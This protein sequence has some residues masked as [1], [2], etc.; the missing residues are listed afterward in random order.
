MAKTLLALAS[1]V[2]TACIA[3]SNT[4]PE[5]PS[6]DAALD[7]EI[8]ELS[9]DASDAGASLDGSDA[10][11]TGSIPEAA[12]NEASDLDASFD[13]EPIEASTCGAVTQRQPDEG[14]VHF[15]PCTRITYLS[16][17]PSSGTHYADIPAFGVYSEPLPRGYW[18]HTLEHGAIV[19]TYNCPEGCADEIA[20]ASEFIQN[21]PIDPLCAASGE[22]T[23][24][25]VLTPDPKLDTRWAASAWNFT[26]RSSCFEP[27]VFRDFYFAHYNHGLENSCG[28]AFDPR[29]DAGKLNLPPNCGN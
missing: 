28:W 5:A 18:V 9:R 4:D 3:C 11:D 19:L 7:P 26:L 15:V 13:A 25:V 8:E 29:T 6:R 17:P 16:N 23:R 14:R 27:G 24:R 20:A 21:L 10:L 12:P 2:A 1:L 22:L